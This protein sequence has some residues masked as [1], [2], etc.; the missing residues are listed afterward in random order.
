MVVGQDH[1]GQLREH[2][3]GVEIRFANDIAKTFDA[4]IVRQ[5]PEGTNRLPSAALS[6]MG[7]GSFVL[8]PD[9]GDQLLVQ[10]KVFLVD[11]E[12]DPGTHDI[13]FGT[14]AYVRIDHGSESIAVQIMRRVRQ[15]FLRQFSV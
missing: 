15:V 6:T 12:F 2:V 4:S 8:S 1:F 13:P 9:A 5:A 7:G 14:R 11:L 10:E 3:E